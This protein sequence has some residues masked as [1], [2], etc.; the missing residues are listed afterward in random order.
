MSLRISTESPCAVVLPPAAAR[1]VRFAGEQLRYYAALLTGARPALVEG[2]EGVTGP[3]L[4]LR[5]E[6]GPA[7]PRRARGADAAVLRVGGDRAE[8]AAATPF[9]LLHGVY[10][11]LERFGGAYWLN[12]WEA[13]E[14]LPRLPCLELPD[15]EWRWEPRFSCRAFTNYPTIDEQTPDFVDWMAKRGFNHYVVNPAFPDV[16]QRCGEF[17]REPLALRGMGLSLDHHTLPF[18]LPPEEHFQAHPEYFALRDGERRPDAQLCTSSPDVA[19][20]VAERV[21]AFLRDNPDVTEVGLWPRDGYGWCE[22][23]ACCSLEPQEPSWWSASL[24]RRTDTYLRFVNAVAERVGEEL[25]RARLTALAYVNYVE[26]PRQVRPLPNVVVYFAPFQR[27]LLHS[28]DDPDCVRRNPDYTRFL[29]QWRDATPGELRV[30]LYVMQIDTLSLP[31]RITD[32]L[33]A[34]FD[35]L[36]SV[37]VDGWMMEYVPE[38]WAT[39]AANAYAISHLAWQEEGRAEARR[40]EDFLRPYYAALYG[41]AAEEMAAYFRALIDDFVDG[42]P[43]TGHYDLTYTRRATPGL[44]RRALAHL[45]R[46][47]LEAADDRAAWR[48]VTRAQIAAELLVRVGEWQRALAALDEATDFARPRRRKL[49]DE[50]AEA[51]VQWAE[52]HA[53]DGVLHVG[54]LRARLRA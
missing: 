45:G 31:Y 22:C 8:L 40:G 38:E 37:G 52:A 9:G 16:W 3:C 48:A 49:C 32:M 44:L 33:P 53:G 29:G 2:P 39:F 5:V 34:H 23:E 35:L 11:L 30:F 50:A 18:W 20:V 4:A 43:C 46:A 12:R 41:P 6:E 15:G 25:P 27:C 36:A 10:R 42:G 21:I 7:A 1:P 19:R 14:P 13:D 24:P 26:P 51:V 28:L 54:K 17:L 47:R